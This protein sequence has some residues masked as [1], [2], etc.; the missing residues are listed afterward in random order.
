MC[1]QIRVYSEL[2]LKWNQKLNLTAIV[3]PREILERHFG[4][5]LFA[6]SMIPKDARTLID[7]GSGAGFPG[8]ALKMARPALEV[9]L[10]EPV[11][12]KAAFLK[13]AA[14]ALELTVKVRSLRI[15]DCPPS[16]MQSDCFTC[17]AVR[18]A[19]PLLH[20]IHDALP[21]GGTMIAW[22]GSNDVGDLKRFSALDWR[23]F[24]IP[25]S[26]Q[27]VLLIGERRG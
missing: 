25:A 19:V 16:E 10:L 15:E 23:E 1:E 21:V 8:L 24:A 7:I 27:R 2:L 5:S 13:E 17:R 11:L 3:E 22:P 9:T 26:Q 12:K 4:E 6:L 14:R 18:L 20:R